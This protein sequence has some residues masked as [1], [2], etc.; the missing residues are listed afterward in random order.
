VVQKRIRTETMPEEFRLMKCPHCGQDLATNTCSACKTEILPESVYCHRCGVRVGS[1][2]PAS[3]P[4]DEEAVDFSSRLLCSDGN[5]IGVIN[6]KGF[7]KVCG[8]PYQ[9][10][11]A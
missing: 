8:K 5:C 10:E 9:G 6:E 7:C 2:V 4:G 3:A 11:P 1:A